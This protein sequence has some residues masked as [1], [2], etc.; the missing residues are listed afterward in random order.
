MNQ[1][2]IIPIKGNVS[3]KKISVIITA[4]GYGKR[5]KSYGNKSLIEIGSRINVIAHQ[6]NCIN[7]LFSHC[8]IIVV[9]GFEADKVANNLPRGIRIVEN[10]RYETTNICRS[11]SLG[12]K[13][14]IYDN[15][16]IVPNDI[17]FNKELISNLPL[18]KSCLILDKNN[19][20]PKE[21][22]GVICNNTRITHLAYSLETKWTTIG[23]LS[24]KESRRFQKLTHDRKNSNCD[25][26]ELVNIIID[27]GGKFLARYPKNMKVTKIYNPK[28]IGRIRDTNWK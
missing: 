28:D 23:Y 5:M 4:A 15:I 17:M 19:E 14:S 10:E 13:A 3:Q 16:L 26:F 25:M 24:G 8:E 2:Y 9:V 20:M 18:D 1:N 11:I 27:R 7:S 21:S 12:I 22:I 6:I